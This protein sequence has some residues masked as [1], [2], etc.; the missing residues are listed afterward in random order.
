MDSYAFWML[1]KYS[2]SLTIIVPVGTNKG[3]KMKRDTQKTLV[4]PTLT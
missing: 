2:S 3:D 4:T 1:G